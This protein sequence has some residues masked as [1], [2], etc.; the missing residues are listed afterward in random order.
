M[1]TKGQGHSL[2]LVQVIHRALS[3][4][5]GMEVTSNGLRHMTKMA[6]IPIYS[7]TFKADDTETW[8]GKFFFSS[9]S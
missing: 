2:T 6:A 8:Y 1:S 9:N 4:D 5:G 3:W 7:K